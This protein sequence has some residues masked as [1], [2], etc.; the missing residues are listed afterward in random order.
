MLLALLF[1]SSGNAQSRGLFDWSWG[2][3]CAQIEREYG[4]D[5]SSFF[6][7]RKEVLYYPFK[8]FGKTLQALFYCKGRDYL[9]GI[10]DGEEHV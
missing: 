5:D 1:M 2:M 4:E 3:S 9:F 8:L 10:G 7:G 6:K